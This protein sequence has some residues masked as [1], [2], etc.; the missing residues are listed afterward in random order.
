MTARWLLVALTLVACA[1]STGHGP[2]P[3][4]AGPATWA[5]Q[6]RIVKAN[7]A[8][9]QRALATSPPGDLVAVANDARAAAAILRQG[10]TTAEQPSV[11]GYARYAREAESWLLQV[12]L[13]ARSAHGELAAERFAAGAGQH[14]TRCHDAVERAGKAG[15]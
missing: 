3:D 5:Q 12:A 7:L 1:T 4:P 6:M 13:E 14:C 9:V 15:G 8:R 11:P 10:Y 2:A